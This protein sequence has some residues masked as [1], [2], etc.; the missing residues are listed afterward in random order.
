LVKWHNKYKDQ[1][2]VILEL[3]DGRIDDRSDVRKHVKKAKYPFA[4]AFDKEARITK[5]YGV[6]AYP[7]GVLIG[8]DGKVIWNGS[9]PDAT[10][11]KLE[12]L[13]TEALAD[14]ADQP[15]KGKAP[16]S[17]ARA[18]NDATTRAG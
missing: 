2:L 12:K 10:P 6:K 9:P 13:I 18:N 8:R 16:A 7:I 14:K 1:G 17:A 3:D 4:V 15:D 11:E 5:Q